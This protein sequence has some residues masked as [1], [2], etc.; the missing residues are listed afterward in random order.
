MRGSRERRLK[1]ATK[2]SSRGKRA[3][4]EVQ[5]GRGS[6][7]VQAGGRRNV[8]GGSQVAVVLVLVEVGRQC[9]AAVPQAFSHPAWVR[10]L[11][12]LLSGIDQQSSGS[13]HQ[14]LEY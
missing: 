14:I 11:G 1:L 10:D 8:H 12:R 13:W 6:E 2:T 7:R 3:D 5:R 4:N 9:K